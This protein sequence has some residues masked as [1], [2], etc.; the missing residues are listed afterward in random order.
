MNNMLKCSV[1]LLVLFAVAL[2]SYA[3]LSGAIF[4][5]D[6][7]DS[8]VNVNNYASKGLVYLN[9][10]PGLHA[11]TNAAG[12]PPGIY[13]F[14][15]TDPPGKTLLSTDPVTCRQFTVGT[16][17]FITDVNPSGACAHKTGGDS[18]TGGVT[19]QMCNP[20]GCNDGFLDT[21]NKGGVY[22]AWVT[23]VGSYSAGAGKFGFIPASSKTDNFKVKANTIREIDTRFHDTNNRGALIDGLGITWIDTLGASNNKYSY[24]NTALDVNHEA[25]V[26][27]V[28][29]GTHQIVIANQ[30]GCI[31]DGN[32]VT[33]TNQNVTTIGPQTMAIPIK[34][35]Y[36]NIT[37]F[38]DVNC[39]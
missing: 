39:N 12:L 13:Y 35:S 20:T 11:P 10:G 17:G 29:D 30:P 8:E 9:G 27:G 3:Q 25:H 28:E 33:V 18:A 15:I 6:P 2:P 1:V 31:V 34:P 21:P 7:T 22:K 24:L 37:I 14:Q 16:G 5:T 23:P 32:S 4:T 38:V 36:K 26:E 19:V